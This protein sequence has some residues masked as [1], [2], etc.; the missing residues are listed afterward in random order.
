VLVTNE[1][2]RDNRKEKKVTRTPKDIFF[3]GQNKNLKIRF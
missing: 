1:K 2:C 3:F